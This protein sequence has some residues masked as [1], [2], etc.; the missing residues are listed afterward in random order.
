[1]IFYII[2]LLSIIYSTGFNTSEWINDT[3][4]SNESNQRQLEIENFNILPRKN[5][6]NDNHFSNHTINNS[7]LNNS[8]SVDNNYLLLS[9][10]ASIP[11]IKKIDAL[12]KLLRVYVDDFRDNSDRV[13]II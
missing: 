6:D 8:N 9:K 10:N 5:D 4:Q 13:K 7:T 2:L 11:P 12:S 1:M 3:V